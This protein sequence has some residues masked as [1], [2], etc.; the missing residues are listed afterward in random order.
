[1]R[2]DTTIFLVDD[3]PAV[4]DS[5]KLLLETYGFT[6]RD[7][8]SGSD[9]LA[10]GARV[11]K[12]CLVLDMHMPVISGLDLLERLAVKRTVPPTVII[13][14]RVDADIRQ[15][16]RR[17]R[18]PGDRKPFDTAALLKAMDAAQTAACD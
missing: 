18:L 9:F 5:L 11:E 2:P 4:R 10:S 14:G 6:M 7:F 12:A 16:A 8:A 3:D 13:T 17:R 15:R 1:M